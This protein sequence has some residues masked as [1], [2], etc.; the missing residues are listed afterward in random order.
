M[1]LAEIRCKEGK[2]RFCLVKILRPRIPQGAAVPVSP[3]QVYSL[4]SA[5]KALLADLATPATDTA[6]LFNG[7]PEGEGTARR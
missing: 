1:L 4:G 3:S 6:T 2:L 7:K 5:I